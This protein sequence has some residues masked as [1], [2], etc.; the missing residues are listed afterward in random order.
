MPR[1]STNESL[2]VTLNYLGLFKEML[3]CMFVISL[4]E[5]TSTLPCFLLVS[6]FGEPGGVNQTLDVWR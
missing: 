1:K 6:S 4:Q 3:P 2:I 5:N